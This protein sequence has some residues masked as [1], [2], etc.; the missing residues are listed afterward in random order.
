[1]LLS[2]C[3]TCMQHRHMHSS[4]YTPTCTHTRSH[5]HKH[6]QTELASSADD[7]LSSCDT[8]N[9]VAEIEG[10]NGVV[11]VTIGVTKADGSKCARYEGCICDYVCVFL[12]ICVCDY[13]FL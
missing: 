3:N 11:S 10:P 4:I 7:L 5:K 9:T 13:V 12:I 2:M 1:M 8:Y 6:A